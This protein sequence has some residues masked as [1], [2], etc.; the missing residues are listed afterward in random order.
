MEVVLDLDIDAAKRANAAGINMIR[1]GTVGSHPAY[2]GMVRD[3]IVERMTGSGERLTIGTLPPKHDF[4]P[5]DCCLSGRPG[6]PRDSLCGAADSEAAADR[7]G[8]AGRGGAAH[9]DGAAGS[10]TE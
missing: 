4:C 10:D 6:P 2:V 7:D 8:A 3:L 5:T 1:A 9:R